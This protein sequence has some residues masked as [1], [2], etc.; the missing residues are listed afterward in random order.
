MRSGKEDRTR[1][2][3]PD[4]YGTHARG[5]ENPHNSATRTAHRLS[6]ASLALLAARSHV[7]T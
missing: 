2:R 5:P 7:R 1:L 4:T 3:H 6:K